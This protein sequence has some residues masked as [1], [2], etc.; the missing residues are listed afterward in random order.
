[1]SLID[2]KIDCLYFL[3]KQF[4]FEQYF[5][6]GK[7][8]LFL[9]FVFIC[10]TATLLLLNSTLF[11]LLSYDFN[12]E[13]QL[14]IFHI[15]SVYDREAIQKQLNLLITHYIY[16]RVKTS[17][18]NSLQSACKKNDS[19]YCNPRN[20]WRKYSKIAVLFHFNV[21]TASTTS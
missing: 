3:D 8:C 20:V 6:D 18:Y 9:L 19:N 11:L 2:I 7:H 4:N 16:G 12:W 15:A 13:Y 10:S 17:L 14:N 5:Y 21:A 1:M